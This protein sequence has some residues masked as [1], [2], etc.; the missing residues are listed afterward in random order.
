MK[1][2]LEFFF[3]GNKLLKNILEIV[4]VFEVFDNLFLEFSGFFTAKL[5]QHY[6][7]M[8]DKKKK[9]TIKIKNSVMIIVLQ[10]TVIPI[11]IKLNLL[12]IGIFH[13]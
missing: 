13:F 10:K 8:T 1:K 12:I 5:W 4:Y 9:P 3:L 7:T 6:N 2:T 11:G